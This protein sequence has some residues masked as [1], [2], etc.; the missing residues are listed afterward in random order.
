MF[1]IKTNFLGNVS[2]VYK[3]YGGI[4]ALFLSSYFYMAVAIS[5]LS[6]RAVVFGTWV[7]ITKSILPN[8]VG[9]SI[10]A[11][12]LLFSVLDRDQR[13]ALRKPSAAIGG[14]SPLLVLASSITHA[15]LIQILA[16]LSAIV[17]WSEPFPYVSCADKLGLWVNIITSSVGMFLTSYGII[18]VMAAALSLFRLLILV[19]S[20]EVK[21]NIESSAPLDSSGAPEER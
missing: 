14:R 8:L 5:L 19:P 9:F 15:I 17:F 20:S 16:L 13:Q 2:E 3:S 10:A 1:K 21:T 4:Q 6:W 12:A 7:E 11:Y 18:L